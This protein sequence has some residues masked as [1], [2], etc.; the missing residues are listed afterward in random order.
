M[1]T[2]GV[3]QPTAK[4]TPTSTR[5]RKWI[6]NNHKRTNYILTVTWIYE[7]RVYRKGKPIE[8]CWKANRIDD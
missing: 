8:G 7:S 1:A 2:N 6:H 5:N 4:Q 3:T